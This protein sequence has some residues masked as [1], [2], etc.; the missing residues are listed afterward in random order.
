MTLPPI[1]SRADWLAARKELLVAE[2]EASRARDRLSARLRTLSMVPVDTGYTFDGRD[3]PVRL[4]DLF[5]GRSQLIV[6]HF[7]FDPAWAEGCR[8]CSFLVDNIGHLSHLHARDTSLVMVSRAPFAKLVAYGERMGWTI[9]WFSSFGSGFNYDFH[10]T[11]DETV[12]PVEYNY[13]EQETLERAGGHTHGETHGL[14]VFLRDG[15]RVF[16]TYST[17]ARGLDPLIGTYVYLDL[18]P[19]GR[20]EAETGPMGWLRHHD[21]YE[22]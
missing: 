2:K 20:Q 12:Q 6:Y 22:S 18:T 3:G 21:R 16:H 7:M 5:G 13:Q 8:S 4:V 11:L 14:S 17:Y 9:P 19:R 10:V 1:A 15:D